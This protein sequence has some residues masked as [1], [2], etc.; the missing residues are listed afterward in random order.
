MLREQ[1]QQQHQH[2]FNRNNIETTENKQI[3][4]IAV[5]I[6]NETEIQSL[7]A[8]TIIENEFKITKTQKKTRLTSFPLSWH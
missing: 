3:M 8:D 5:L 4:I 6:Y 2:L 1:Q 7:I